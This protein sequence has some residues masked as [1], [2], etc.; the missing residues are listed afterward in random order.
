MMKIIT[1]FFLF[2]FLIFSPAID[3]QDDPGP[4]GYRA[5]GE[6]TRG[7]EVEGGQSGVRTPGSHRLRSHKKGMRGPGGRGARL[8]FKKFRQE[9]RALGD[10]IIENELMIQ[11]LEEELE[12]L[13][14]GESRTEVSKK[15]KEYRLRE[16]E[17]QIILANKRVDFTRRARDLA[18]ERYDQALLGMG[19]VKEKIERDYPELA[20]SLEPE[21]NPADG[22][23]P[24]PE[25]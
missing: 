18:Q 4:D 7:S 17:L 24:N 9:V 22:P 12:M 6:F 2:M 1:G 8:Q 3:A 25:F 19:K 13:E 5:Q 14:P 16:A 20:A 15:L 10:E 21:M 23:S 11:S